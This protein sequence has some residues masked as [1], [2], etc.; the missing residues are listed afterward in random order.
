MEKNVWT[1]TWN[2]RAGFYSAK[3][4]NH[5]GLGYSIDPKELDAIRDI[6]EDP[7]LTL[8]H[9]ESFRNKYMFK[10]LLKGKVKYEMIDDHTL[11]EYIEE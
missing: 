1:L 6:Q 8:L 11:I 3:C 5:A 7:N 4:T 10:M 2:Q 9:R